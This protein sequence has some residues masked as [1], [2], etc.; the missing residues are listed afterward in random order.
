MSVKPEATTTPV[1]TTKETN[2]RFHAINK[3][4]TTFLMENG[5]PQELMHTWKENANKLKS[6]IKKMD[7]VNKNPPRPMNE[8]IYFCKEIRPIVQNEMRKLL[9]EGETLNNHEVTCEMGRRWKHF[10]QFPDEEMKKKLG[11]LA[12]ADRKRYYEEKELLKDKS[13][14]GGKYLRSKYLFF[15]HEQ[16]VENPNINMKMLGEAWAA[17]KTDA[18]L[19]E[20]Y[21]SAAAKYKQQQS[22]C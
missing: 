6:V 20:R 10:S 18:E 7:K 2:A 13:D 8:Y 4:F 19:T 22:S 17:M 5:A 16:R 3:F 1:S 15:C 11:E 12:A 9:K 14:N 21:E